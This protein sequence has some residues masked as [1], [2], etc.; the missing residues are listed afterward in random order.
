M[1]TF[2]TRLI[3]AEEKLQ[4][5]IKSDSLFKS[6]ERFVMVLAGIVLALDI[7]LLIYDHFNTVASNV[8]AIYCITIT[9][10]AL[11]LTIAVTKRR[12]RN[13]LRHNNGIPMQV[14]VI[15]VKTTRAVRRED[16]E[17]FGTAF[18]IDVTNEGQQKTLFLWGQYLDILN[19]ENKFP[20]TEFE[21]VRLPNAQEFIEFKLSGYY[22]K[23][24]RTLPA[25]AKQV[26]QSG[27]CPLNGQLMDTNIEGI[28]E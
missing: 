1:I 28:L 23:E 14:E 25:F 9:G 22:F 13:R 7:P 12:S 11:F 2:T 24:E 10:I 19:D 6:I 3:T 20:N 16:F 17:D 5:S 4:V 26:W 27:T 18:Y 15:K 8:Q 21:I